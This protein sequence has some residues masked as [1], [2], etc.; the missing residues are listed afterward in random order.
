MRGTT[1]DIQTWKKV[2]F[3]EERKCNLDG[4]DGFSMRHSGGG[5]I[6]V[7]GV[8]SFN[9]TMELQVVKGRHTTAGYVEML[10]GASI[11]TEGLVY[12]VMTGFFNKT[13]LQSTTP[14]LT[15]LDKTAC[16]PD[17]GMDERGSLQK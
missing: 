2:I 9:G 17:L 10:Q 5:A 8:F 15:V 3:S 1:W 12:V 16:V 11:M 6:M 7:W 14:D 4:S 13:M